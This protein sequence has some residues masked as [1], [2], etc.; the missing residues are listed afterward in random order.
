MVI[1][2]RESSRSGVMRLHLPGR[3]RPSDLADHRDAPGSQLNPNF[4]PP[5]GCY[6]VS[7]DSGASWKKK[8][9]KNKTG[10]GFQKRKF[11][12]NAVNLTMRRMKYSESKKSS[13]NLDVLPFSSSLFTIGLF[14]LVLLWVFF[15]RQ[16]HTT[17]SLTHLPV[18]V[19]NKSGEN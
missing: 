3:M 9:K 13:H 7:S 18:A 19:S 15:L 10:F 2:P 8:T 1:R 16:T 17:H 6:F 14:P 4:F 12:Y 5:D 11:C